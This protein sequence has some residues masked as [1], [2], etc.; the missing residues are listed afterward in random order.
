VDEMVLRDVTFTLESVR[1]HGD[2][3]SSG[4]P[5]SPDE[6]ARM[7]G[8]VG[9]SVVAGQTRETAGLPRRSASLDIRPQEFPDPNDSQFAPTEPADW[10][11][12]NVHPSAGTTDNEGSTGEYAHAPV[13]MLTKTGVIALNSWGAGYGRVPQQPAPGPARPA[14]PDD[15]PF[16]HDPPEEVQ[17]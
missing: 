16:D 11:Y 9:E 5:A 14:L 3:M 13:L 8:R 15:H 2:R 7:I 12:N 17:P 1:P 10:I 4:P 6:V